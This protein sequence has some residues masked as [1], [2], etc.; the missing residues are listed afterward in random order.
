[1]F[2]LFAENTPKISPGEMVVGSLILMLCLI[3]TTIWFYLGYRLQQGKPPLPLTPRAPV[4]WGVP[5]IFVTTVFLLL[6]MFN[7]LVRSQTEAPAK[8]VVPL[9]LLRVGS[10]LNLVIIFVLAVLLVEGKWKRFSEFGITLKNYWRNIGIG[11][12]GCLAALPMVFLVSYLI[13]SFRT[14]E[15]THVMLQLLQEKPSVE[16]IAWIGLAVVVLA[17]LAEELLFRVIFQGMLRTR[18]SVTVSI[19]ISSTVFAAVHGFPDMVGL[20]PLAIVFGYVYERTHSYLAVVVLH[21]AF[22]ATSLALALLQV[23]L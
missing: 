7:V 2:L 19:L 22:N 16:I 11:F 15:N 1:M 5:V 6:P 14:K 18:L 10:L 23:F 12:L 4:K 9:D 17:P 21:A 3:G 20:L 13:K 8:K